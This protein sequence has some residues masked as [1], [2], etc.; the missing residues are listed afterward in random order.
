M[1]EAAEASEAGQAFS[2]EV[3]LGL[4]TFLRSYAKAKSSKAIK[5]AKSA[6]EVKFDFLPRSTPNLAVIARRADLRHMGEALPA[7]ET[8]SPVLDFDP[9]LT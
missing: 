1:F 5:L 3:L 6:I 4:F 2:Q 7:V 8:V 9:L